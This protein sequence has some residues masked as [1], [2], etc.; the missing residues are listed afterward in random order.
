M[1]FGAR[2]II[3]IQ[4]WSDDVGVSSI[5]VW[6]EWDVLPIAASMS[7]STFVSLKECC[8]F[9]KSIFYI[10]DLDSHMNLLSC[11]PYKFDINFIIP[12]K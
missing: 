2:P 9:T 10:K 1:D 4:Q 6:S 7:A 3:K 5:C 8:N 12:E 11:L